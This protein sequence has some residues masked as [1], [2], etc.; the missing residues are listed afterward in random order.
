MSLE[1]KR[2]TIGL[3]AC[4]P[5]DQI[6]ALLHALRREGAELRVT[7]TPN[8]LNFIPKM[9]LRRAANCLVEIDQ[10]EE[11]AVF[12]PAHRPMSDADLIVIAPASANTIGKAANGIADNLLTVT[13]LS[14][15]SPVMF[16]PN[17]NP[18][19]YANAAV[20]RNIRQL[21]EDGAIFVE[22]TDKPG[23]MV[24]NEIILDAIRAVFAE[25]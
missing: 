9:P 22:N 20:Q 2:I 10:F 16:V 17:I 4:T 23:R 7:M 25:D 1:G 21:K 6:P 3:T 24:S 14:A 15:S 8:A 19:M 18:K 11:P 5:V 13:V 12:D